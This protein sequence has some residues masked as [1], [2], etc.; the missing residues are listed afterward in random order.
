MSGKIY[1]LLVGINDYPDPRNQLNGCLTDVALQRELLIHRYGFNPNDVKELKNGEATRRGILDAFERH[2]IQQAKPG[3]VVVFHYSGHGCKVADSD[4]NPGR[5]QKGQGFNGAIVP[6]DSQTSTPGTIRAIMGH[7]L[8]LLTAA[9]Q[10][11]NVTMVLD[12]CFSGGGLRGN[13]QIR[14]LRSPEDD[15]V[16]TISN[17]EFADQQRLLSKLKLNLQAFVQQRKAGIAKGIAMGAASPQQYSNEAPEHVFGR[18]LNAG[19]FTYLLTQYLWQQGIDEPIEQVFDRLQLGTE[20]IVGASQKPVYEAKQASF[21]QK[22]VYFLESG[23][24]SAEA[25]VNKPPKNNQ[26]ILLWLGGVSPK[27]LLTYETV[28]YNLLDRRGAIVGKIQQ[29]SRDGLQAVGKLLP[30]GKVREVREGMLLQ[31]QVRGMP[32]NLVLRVGL[33]DSLGDDLATA[34]K[35]LQ[36]VG[37]VEIVPV[38]PGQEV[39]Y[40]LGRMTAKTARQLASQKLTTLPPK[41]TLCLFNAALLPIAESSGAVGESIETA[42]RRLTPKLKSLLAVRILQA[43]L[44]TDASSLRVSTEIVPVLAG[45]AGEARVIRSRGMQQSGGNGRSQITTSQTVKAGAKLQIRLRNDE[46]QPLYIAVLVISDNGSLT[47]LYPIGRETTAA[48]VDKRAALLVP[49]PLTVSGP[50]GFFE[51]MV[52]ASR[53]ELKGALEGINRIAGDRGLIRGE[54]ASLEGDEPLSIVGQLIRD[55]DSLSRAGGRALVDSSKL[56]VLSTVFQVVE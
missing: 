14:A 49:V 40:L 10:T 17:E 39:D 33:D 53:E 25:V 4:P 45:V 18:Q 52:V 5:I 36:S 50:S 7:T 35:L 44:G 41:N 11:E 42:V 8:F 46:D 23:Q 54:P 29:T 34:Q 27:T 51:L 6:F 28:E 9:L 19:A 37:R 21:K 43:I 20:V 3:D 22:S 26:E 31:E 15:Q 12:S 55:I 16:Y 30:G 13:T 1:A 38:K 56:A 32:E 48:L 24:P 2:L 47:V